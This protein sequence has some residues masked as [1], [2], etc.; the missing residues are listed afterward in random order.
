LVLS[1]ALKPESLLTSLAYPILSLAL[2]GHKSQWRRQESEVRGQSS[3]GLGTEVPQQGPGAAEPRWGWKPP[4]AEK[5]DINFALR[6]TL[7]NAYRPFYSS[8]II[9]FVTGFTRRSHIS[10][11]QSLPYSSPSLLYYHVHTFHRIC[12][13]LRIESRTGWG[14]AAPFAPPRGDANDESTISALKMDKNDPAL[15][16][17]KSVAVFAKFTI[18]GN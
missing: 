3:E 1:L 8:Y 13:N 6:I 14:A 4:E 15:L 17:S 16:C 9:M 7:V 12:T 2:T 11:F 18:F 10:D 5:H